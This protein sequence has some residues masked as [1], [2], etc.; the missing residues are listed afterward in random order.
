[1]AV[2]AWA[3]L[4]VEFTHSLKLHPSPTPG[5]P[6][7]T[8]HSGHF[9]LHLLSPITTQLSPACGRKATRQ[10]AELGT[11]HTA[12]CRLPEGHWALASSD[13]LSLQE[14]GIVTFLLL[15]VEWHVRVTPSNGVLTHSDP[16]L[17]LQPAPGCTPN[18]NTPR[19]PFVREQAEALLTSSLAPAMP[20]VWSDPLS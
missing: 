8:G 9:P 18:S 14:M 17:P 4:Q 16:H 10:H 12:C 19:Y 20:S 7:G 1:M 11:D 2:D 5:C 13:R 3:T 6:R 15:E